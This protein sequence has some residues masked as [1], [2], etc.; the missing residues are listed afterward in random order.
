MACRI[1]G[2]SSC[3]CKYEIEPV[4][5]PTPKETLR[6]LF[7]DHAVYTHTYII[8][9]LYQ[10]PS[11]ADVTKRLLENQKEIGD[12]AGGFLGKKSG[13]ALTKLLTQHIL[14]AS[15][16]VKAA[17]KGDSSG[18][19]GK[20]S[21]LFDNSRRVAELLGS[22]QPEKVSSEEFKLHFDQHNQYVIDIT[23]LYIS[24]KFDEVISTYDCYYTHMLMF[25]D[26][27]WSVLV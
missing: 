2:E 8:N 24:R 26:L 12:A 17:A 22:I 10:L 23:T 5:P 14:D 19:K 16:V 7:T 13:D 4:E 15:A 21:A 9:E 3:K 11:L 20:I 6:K 25:S 18:I 27:V 1:T